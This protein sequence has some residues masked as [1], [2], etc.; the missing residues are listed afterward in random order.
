MTKTSECETID[1]KFSSVKKEIE[2][3]VKNYEQ[4]DLKKNL[5]YFK[6]EDKFRWEKAHRVE[7]RCDGDNQDFY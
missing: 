7:E 3:S 5:S 1:E 4:N 2:K 6:S